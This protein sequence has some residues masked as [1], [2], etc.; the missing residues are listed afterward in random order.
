MSEGQETLRRREAL[1]SHHFYRWMSR[2]YETICCVLLFWRP[3]NNGGRKLRMQLASC[4]KWRKHVARLRVANEIL[5]SLALVQHIDLYR[6]VDQ[7]EGKME[8][9]SGCGENVGGLSWFELG[10][11]WICCNRGRNIAG[12]CFA[13][14]CEWSAL[15]RW[16]SATMPAGWRRRLWKD[17]HHQRGAADR[18]LK[19]SIHGEGKQSC[20]TDS[21]KKRCTLPT[22]CARILPCGQCICGSP[23]CIRSVSERIVRK[24]RA[25]GGIRLTAAEWRA[26]TGSGDAEHLQGTEHFYSRLAKLGRR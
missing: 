1:R 9:S 5:Q 12:I 22:N 11:A 10:S 4:W 23:Q 15:Q 6:Q 14:C 18:C 24:T 26:W 21:R 8:E 2:L 25:P 3:Q 7:A 19:Q 17:S 20:A 16:C 13:A